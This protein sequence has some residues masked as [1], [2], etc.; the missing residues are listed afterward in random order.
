MSN[1]LIVH[2]H[3]EPKSFSSALART[4]AEAFIAQGHSVEFSDLYAQGFNPV[5]DRR[6]FTTVANPDYLKQ[7][8]EEQYATKNNG[9]APDLEA[10][11][12]KVEKCDLMIFSFP[13][14]WFGLPAILKGWVDR[15]FAMGRFYGRG[16]WYENGMGRGK[17]ALVLMTTGGGQ[18]MYGRTGMHPTIDKVL[19]PVHHG[20]FWFNGFSPV[21]PFVAWSAAH[22][23]DEQRKATLE[24]LRGRLKN[25]F[26]EPVIQ[27]P[28]AAEF[29]KDTFA[30]TF[31][32]FMATAAADGPLDAEAVRLFPT[33][34]E[35]LQVLQREGGLR[36]FHL[37]APSSP[38]W[39]GFLFFRERTEAAV[40]EICQS[41]PLAAGWKWEITQVMD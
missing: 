2:A 17:R 23:T 12:R 40:R 15:V 4:A 18:N 7:Q 22:G 9:F 35:R 39:R 30:D 11:M 16:K 24:Q 38:D 31:A 29:E 21:P 25:I 27:L 8:D 1:I 26:E 36:D 20:I 41:L 3:H 14:W 13:L 5:S 33:L 37:S 6:N 32:R 19:A 10:E 28:R 34:R